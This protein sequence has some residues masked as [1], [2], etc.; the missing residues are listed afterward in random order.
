MT[1][2]VGSVEVI[3]LLGPSTASPGSGS[4][5][6]GHALLPHQAG[7][8]LPPLAQHCLIDVEMAALAIF[9]PHDEVYVRVLLMGMQDHGVSMRHTESLPCKNLGCREHLL[10]VGRRGPNSISQAKIGDSRSE[11]FIHGPKGQLRQLRRGEQ[12]DV[13]PA[14]TSPH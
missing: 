10:R 6:C 8:V 4:R 2:P 3:A 11:P 1:A 9:S 7:E 14:E 5:V 13:D 12:V